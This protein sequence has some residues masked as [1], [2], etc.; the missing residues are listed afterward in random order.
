MKRF[1]SVNDQQVAS[2]L[3]SGKV[4]I[5]RTDTLYGLVCRADDEAAVNRVYVLKDRGEHKSPIVLIA[6]AAQLFDQPP[7]FANELLAQSWPG[8]VSIILPSTK[9]PKWL[10]RENESIAYRLPDSADLQQLIAATGPLIAPS[11]N[12]EGREPAMSIDEAYDYFG[13]SVDFYVDGGLVKDNT[14]SRLILVK[15]DG[16]TVRLR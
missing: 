6:S 12:P 13:E 1:T 4:G 15:Q 7:A 2:L 14:P 3:K 9:A 10:R 8:S 16:T 11:A 5:L